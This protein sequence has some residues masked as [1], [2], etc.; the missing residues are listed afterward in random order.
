VTQLRVPAEKLSEEFE[1]ALAAANKGSEVLVEV[2]GAVVA[3]LVPEGH[4]VDWKA[5]WQDL[6]QLKLDDAFADAVLQAVRE[7]NRP[8]EDV[9]WES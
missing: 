4:L 9:P 5:F 2:D 3:R 6:E 8:A 1:E 7:H